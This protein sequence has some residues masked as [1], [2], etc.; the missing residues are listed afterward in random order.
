MYKLLGA[1]VLTGGTYVGVGYALRKNLKYEYVDLTKIERVS[2]KK[3]RKFLDDHICLEKRPLDST[4]IPE[5]LDYSDCFEKFLKDNVPKQKI[6]FVFDKE[7]LNFIRTNYTITE[8]KKEGF[9]Y[10]YISTPFEVDEKKFW[11][12]G[13]YQIF[14]LFQNNFTQNEIN[15][16][17][18]IEDIID[19]IMFSDDLTQEEID[20]I[21]V[22]L[23]LDKNL[24]KTRKISKMYAKLLKI[25]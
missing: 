5:P 12:E 11:K 8:Q 20:E 4:E 9:F 18:N 22:K 1:L 15:S 10:W 25:F 19:E 17:K 24:V 23:Y 2:I 6:K 14:G 3:D 13:P 21:F 7:S 16:V